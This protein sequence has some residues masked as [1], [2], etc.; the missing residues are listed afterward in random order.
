MYAGVIIEEKEYSLDIHHRGPAI[1]RDEFSSFSE[2]DEK[3]LIRV[4]L[5]IIKTDDSPVNLLNV[6]FS[7]LDI[8]G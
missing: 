5:D 7:S 2:V 8:I 3:S 4:D 6:Q 1:A